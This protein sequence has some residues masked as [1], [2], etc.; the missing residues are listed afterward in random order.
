MSVGALRWLLLFI[1]NIIYICHVLQQKS[2]WY[3]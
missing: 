1:I 2:E 3:N